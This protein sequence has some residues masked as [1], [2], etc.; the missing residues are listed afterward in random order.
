MIFSAF[1]Q[2][3]AGRQRS[4]TGLGLTISRSMAQHLGGDLTV[5]S[6]I[7]QGST[8]TFTFTANRVPD[9]AL[10]DS[11]RARGPRR[12]DPAETRRKALV[13][14]DVPSNRELLE[15]ALSRAGFE[16][17]GAVSGEEAIEM[18]RAWGPDLVLMDLHMPGMGGMAAIK[19]LRE[20]DSQAVIIVTTAGADDSS[21]AAVSA[22]GAAGLVRKPY[23][24]SDLFETIGRSMGVRFI[25]VEGA[26]L[27]PADT[28]RPDLAMLVH[29][30]PANL[31]AELREACRQARAPRLVQLADRVA[32]HSAQAA[33]A[34]RELAN[35]FQYR[36][37]LEALEGA[38][39][40]QS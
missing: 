29:A 36:A 10:P 16:T 40:G 31:I 32:E 21:D 27:A 9:S 1:G 19:I 18:H 6:T 15:E 28:Q 11:A 39:D 20:S 23:R 33:E 7:G 12:L 17:R 30:I 25:E 37:L 34:I 5:R 24:E 13:V 26:R 8:F 4:G 22:A 38:K 2:A 35:S 14:D 3:E